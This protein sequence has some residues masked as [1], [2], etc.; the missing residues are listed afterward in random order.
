MQSKLLSKFGTWSIPLIIF[1]TGGLVLIVI[2]GV[3]GIGSKTHASHSI[4]DARIYV[5]ENP[6]RLSLAIGNSGDVKLEIKG[7]KV[8]DRTYQL[9]V[10]GMLGTTTLEVGQRA[11]LDIPLQGEFEAGQKY[12]LEIITD[13]P[14]EPKNIL[15]AGATK[16]YW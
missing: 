3:L 5:D 9:P 11:T 12:E 15:D 16:K 10:E 6:P 4:F 2:Y 8:A 1:Y 13:P 14:S 7:I